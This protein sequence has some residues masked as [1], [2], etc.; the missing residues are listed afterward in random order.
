MEIKSYKDLLVWKNG[1]EISK[2]AYK[3]AN[4]LPKEEIFGLSSQIKRSSVSISSNIAEGR[5]RNTRKDFVQFLHIAQG[6]LLELETQIIL[7]SEIYPLVKIQNII[8]IMEEE[9]KMLSVMI[10]K[11]KANSQQLK[12]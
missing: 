1:I 7:V 6:S 2:E 4:Q 11:L 3:I 5:G 12:A 9:K 8:K 10:S